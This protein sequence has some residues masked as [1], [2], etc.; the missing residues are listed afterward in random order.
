[1]RWRWPI[2]LLMACM[3]GTALGIGLWMAWVRPPNR[4]P[5]P[6]SVPAGDQEIAWINNTSAGETWIRLEAGIG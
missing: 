3:L 4:L 2:L 5:T 6:L 1:M